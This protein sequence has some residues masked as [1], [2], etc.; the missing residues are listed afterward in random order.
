MKEEGLD[1]VTNASE[2]FLED[3]TKG[4]PGTAIM[5][6]I[7]GTRPILVEIQSLLT[8]TSFGNPKRMASG[9]IIIVYL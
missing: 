4:L 1:E 9:W 3:R 5:A 6:S 8:P 2:V 7:E